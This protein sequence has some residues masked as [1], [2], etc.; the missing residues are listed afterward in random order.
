MVADQARLFGKVEALLEPLVPHMAT[1]ER[2]SLARSLFSAVHGLVLLGLEEKLAPMPLATLRAEVERLVT[3]M[4]KGLEDD[5][6]MKTPAETFAGLTAH[7]DRDVGSA[8]ARTREPETRR[9]LARLELLSRRAIAAA[10]AGLRRRALPVCR[11]FAEAIEDG[12]RQ[13]RASS[14]RTC[15]PWSLS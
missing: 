7:P 8:F 11:H 3:A 10:A 13:G 15:A 12:D 6:P 1:A 2:A 5:G 9:F 14:P 4:A